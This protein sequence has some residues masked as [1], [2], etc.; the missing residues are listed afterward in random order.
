[1]PLFRRSRDR[2]YQQAARLLSEGRT[3]EAAE[4]LREFLARH[5]DDSNAMV[6][7][8]V[9]LV[10]VQKEPTLDSSNTQEALALLDQ[11]ADLNPR[12]PV[13]VFNKGVCQRTLG[14]LTEALESFEAA[15]EIEDRLPLAILHMAEINYEMENWEKAVELAR[16]ALVR[17]PGIEGALTWVP[18]AMKNAGYMDEEGNVVNAPWEEANPDG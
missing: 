16:L 7:L 5:P 18:E 13:A 11:A 6:S 17:D 4:K 9:A 8:A 14:L 12:D 3:E 15:L 2:Q 1:M 10:Q